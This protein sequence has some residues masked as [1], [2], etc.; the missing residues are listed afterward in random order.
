MTKQDA[1]SFPS[2]PASD[3]GNSA[4]WSGKKINPRSSFF[5]R[6]QEGKRINPRSHPFLVS[7]LDHRYSSIRQ[8]KKSHARFHKIIRSMQRGQNV[9][10]VKSLT[11][12]GNFLPKSQILPIVENSEERERPYSHP[13]KSQSKHYSY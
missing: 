6:F 2:L 8:R 5:S 13:S 1:G 9:S 11:T 10:R 12:S 3:L 4:G 7:D